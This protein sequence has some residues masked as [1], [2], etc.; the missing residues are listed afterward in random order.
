MM[1]YKNSTKKLISAAVFA[2]LGLGML[3][4]VGQESLSIQVSDFSSNSQ[5]R[6]I[7]L[8]EENGNKITNAVK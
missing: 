5:L 7:F 3:W 1:M 2:G 6:T 4:V 8:A